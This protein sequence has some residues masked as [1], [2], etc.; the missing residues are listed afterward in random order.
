[1]PSWPSRGVRA[2]AVMTRRNALS[3]RISQP[4]LAAKRRVLSLDL[5]GHGQALVEREH[6]FFMVRHSHCDHHFVEQLRS[7]LDYIFMTQSQRVKGAG[8][9]GGHGSTHGQ[10]L[11]NG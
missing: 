10:G 2:H 1:M 5:A 9:H 7:A 6:G 8:I 3:T 11:Q 4:A